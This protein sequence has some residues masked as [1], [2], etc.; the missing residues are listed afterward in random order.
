MS[1]LLPIIDKPADMMRLQYA[2]AA[3]GNEQS[4]LIREHNRIFNWL[5]DQLRA[6]KAKNKR[7]R[8]KI[9]QLIESTTR[10]E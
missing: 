7:L 6:E 4:H 10:H 5:I 2:K 1:N 8:E 9:K 3:K